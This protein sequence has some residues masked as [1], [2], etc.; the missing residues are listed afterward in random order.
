[1]LDN[2]FLD[3]FGEL[4]SESLSCPSLSYI[5][6]KSEKY[7]NKSKNKISIFT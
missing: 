5:Y 3:V 4:T 2:L 1:M 7:Y 6:N